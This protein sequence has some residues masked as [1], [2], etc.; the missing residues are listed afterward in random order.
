MC[1]KYQKENIIWPDFVKEN[2]ASTGKV[3]GETFTK[4]SLIYW[5]PTLP[6]DF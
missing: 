2:M 1:K 3:S 5:L 6:T 4:I